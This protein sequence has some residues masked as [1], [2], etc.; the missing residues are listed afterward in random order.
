MQVLLHSVPPLSS[1]KSFSHLPPLHNHPPPL[2]V[3]PT[4][5]RSRTVRRDLN[6]SGVL[7]EPTTLVVQPSPVVEAL[8]VAASPTT[9]EQG[10]LEDVPLL[11]RP[12]PPLSALE[13]LMASRGQGEAEETAAPQLAESARGRRD[14]RAEAVSH[15]PQSCLISFTSVHYLPQSNYHKLINHLQDNATAR[16]RESVTRMFAED[17]SVGESPAEEAVSYPSLTLTI[18][19]TN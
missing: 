10:N 3:M 19:K 18:S 2:Y 14:R 6:S 17:R 4:L 11:S 1:H 16:L 8:S 5:Q 15:H 13:R 9:S 7:D 12:S